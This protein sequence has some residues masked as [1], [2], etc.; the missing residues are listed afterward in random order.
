MTLQ[1]DWLDHRG[2]LW[3]LTKGT[4]GVVL[5]TGQ[6]GLGWSELDHTFTRG[7]LVHVSSRVKRGVHHL[8]VL[9]G[10]NKTDADY[11][12]LYSEWWSQANSPFE[13]GELI[14]TRPDGVTRSRRLR[15]FESPDTNFAFDPGLG[16][17]PPPELWSLTG[18]YGWWY[19]PEQIQGF[20]YK[21]FTGGTSTPFY[22][23]GGAGWPLYISSAYSA[24]GATVTNDGQGPM[25]LTWTLSGP[26]T[27]PR[28]GIHGA[29]ELVYTGVIPA[30][31]VVQITTDPAGRE[32]VETGSNANRYG[33]VSGD[34]SPVPAGQRIPL[35][36]SAEGMSTGSAMHVSGRAAYAQAI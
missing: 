26:L 27:N 16:I 10:W 20:S 36:M 5:D 4:Q 19:G 7:D 32:V 13:L 9:V 24:S 3:D 33:Q 14:V 15:L 25:W 21:D 28:V 8:K 29:G 31:E 12:R 6:A 34:W 11:Y 23:S 35:I 30:G 1:V 2:K 18:D 17:D 22:G